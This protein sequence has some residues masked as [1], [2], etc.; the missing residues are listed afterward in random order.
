VWYCPEVLVHHRIPIERMRKSYFR[1][2]RY[3]QGFI[4]A[5]TSNEASSLVALLRS[6]SGLAW[7]SAK[8]MAAVATNPGG[9]FPAQLKVLRKA[10]Y[11]AGLVS[12]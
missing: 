10:G 2:W 7:F 8:Y 11:L 1:K 12:Q 4:E 9:A 6:I 3:D 5:R